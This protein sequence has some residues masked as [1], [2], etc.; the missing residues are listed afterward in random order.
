MRNKLE[1][2]RQLAARQYLRAGVAVATVAA[3]ALSFALDPFDTVMTDVTT[4]VTAY[5]G[6][7]VVLGGVSV[8]FMVGLKYVK[9]IRGAA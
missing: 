6:A 5:A 7:L 8:A 2:L 3:P 1:T 9:K 4:K